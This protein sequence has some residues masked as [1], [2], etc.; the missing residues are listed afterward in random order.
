[1]GEWFGDLQYDGYR[2]S[3]KYQNSAQGTGDFWHISC[4][5]SDDLNGSTLG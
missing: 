5:R 3:G 4:T 1:V 2:K